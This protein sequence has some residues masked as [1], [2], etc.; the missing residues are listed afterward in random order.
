M[1][2]GAEGEKEFRLTF[3]RSPVELL[4][5]QSHGRLARIKMEINTLEVRETTHTPCMST[6][7]CTCDRVTGN[8]LQPKEQGNTKSSLAAW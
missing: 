2:G 6:C 3:L 5:D 7:L 1:G 8:L 4:A